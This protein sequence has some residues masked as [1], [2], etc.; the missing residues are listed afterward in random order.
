MEKVAEV[1]V[2]TV[3]MVCDKCGKGLMKPYGNN[4]FAT[5]PPQ[6]PHEC[7]NCGHIESY[8]FQYPYRK[9]VPLEPLRK[10]SKRE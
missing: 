7:N 8:P 2:L 10:P 4:V 6:Y 9:L 1:K 5:Y 3:E